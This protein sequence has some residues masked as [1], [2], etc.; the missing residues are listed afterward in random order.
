MRTWS[1]LSDAGTMRGTPPATRPGQFSIISGLDWEGL[2]WEGLDCAGA[3]C[4]C[5]CMAGTAS[6]TVIAVSAASFVRPLAIAPSI[7]PSRHGESD[8]LRG[9][10]PPGCSHNNANGRRLC[11]AARSARSKLRN[12]V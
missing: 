1:D 6:P 9:R 10:E 11:D 5:R 4:A 7:D 2:A 3:G 8:T 12:D